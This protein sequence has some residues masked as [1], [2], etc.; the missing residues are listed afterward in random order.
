MKL[1]KL[2]RHL[3]QMINVEQINENE[4]SITWDENSPEESIFNTWTEEDFIR[5]L[6]DYVEKIAPKEDE[7]SKS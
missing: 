5:A 4:F 3:L 7:R 6:K 1:H 2:P